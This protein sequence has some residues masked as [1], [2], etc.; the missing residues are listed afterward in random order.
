M[1]LVAALIQLFTGVQGRWTGCKPEP[2]Q[3]IYFANHTSHFDFLVL[4]AVLPHTMR[5]STTAVGAADYWTKTAGRR[6]LADKVFKVTLIDREKVTRK[7][8]PVTQLVAVLDRGRSLIIFPEGGRTESGEMQEFK[9][10][11][12]HLAKSRPDVV[13]IP[14]Y[15][16]N[17]NRVLPK[18]EIVAVPFICSVTFGSPIR[19]AANEP[20]DEFLKRAR[21]A[22]EECSVA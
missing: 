18:G 5:E 13:L 19:L 10:G 7:N 16:D 4:W 21:Q 11:I 15:I 3:R 8:N 14:T 12:Y 9:G 22:V 6:W 17:A 2:E 1:N 20:K